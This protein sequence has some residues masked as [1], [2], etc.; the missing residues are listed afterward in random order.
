MIFFIFFVRCRKVSCF[1]H[2][3]DRAYDVVHMYTVYCIS[4]RSLYFSA[5]QRRMTDSPRP[6]PLTWI[7]RTEPHMGEEVLGHGIKCAHCSALTPLPPLPMCDSYPHA[8][9]R[10]KKHSQDCLMGQ[11]KPRRVAAAGGGGGL[12]FPRS[13][14]LP[15]RALCAFVFRSG[16]ESPI[17]ILSAL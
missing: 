12:F 16:S 11:N 13:R 9:A 3:F 17:T 10:T 8:N 14:P 6:T 4:V 5:P 1:W 7:D 2:G 15:R